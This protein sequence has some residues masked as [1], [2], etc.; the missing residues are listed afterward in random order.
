MLHD[1]RSLGSTLLKPRRLPK[2]RSPEASSPEASSPE[3]SSESIR[4]CSATSKTGSCHELVNRSDLGVDA[5]MF[6]V[7]TEQTAFLFFKKKKEEE[8]ESNST[9]EELVT[10]FSVAH[11]AGWRPLLSGITSGE[12]V[13]MCE[14]PPPSKSVFQ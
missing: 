11:A 14:A 8:P 1:F 12:E 6:A 13:G 3:A 2:L 4:W 7:P 5:A 10:R 9:P